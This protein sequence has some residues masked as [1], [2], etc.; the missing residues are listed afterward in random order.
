M[1]NLKNST[2]HF[3]I[4]LCLHPPGLADAN[5][6]GLVVLGGSFRCLLNGILHLR[7]VFLG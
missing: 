4:F 6:D 2:A 7:V 3:N 1:T 5:S